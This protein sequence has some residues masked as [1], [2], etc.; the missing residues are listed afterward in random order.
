MR[1]PLFFFFLFKIRF[2]ISTFLLCSS[3]KSTRCKRFERLVCLFFPVFLEICTLPLKEQPQTQ[4]LFWAFFFSSVCDFHSSQK[5]TDSA[6]TCPTERHCI[7]R[8]LVLALNTTEVVSCD[9][10]QAKTTALLLVWIHYLITNSA[11]AWRVCFDPFPDREASFR[12][13]VWAGCLW[14]AARQPD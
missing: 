13:R 14:L 1:G 11:G 8:L 10:Q 4:P 3:N 12:R 6:H 5:S 2:H 7:P 9:Q